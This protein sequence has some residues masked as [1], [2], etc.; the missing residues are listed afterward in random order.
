MI[1]PKL[2]KFWMEA[3]SRCKK[4][5]DYSKQKLVQKCLYLCSA[6]QATLRTMDKGTNWSVC[7]QMAIDEIANLEITTYL[8]VQTIRGL[9]QK[10]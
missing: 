10:I 4:L 8:G 3:K 5:P 1:G 2:L 6:Y 9:N 7:C